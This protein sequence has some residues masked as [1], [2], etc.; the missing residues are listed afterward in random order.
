MNNIAEILFERNI[1]NSNKIA[2]RDPV[3]AI[4]YGEL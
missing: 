3:E 1:N 2:F 4:T